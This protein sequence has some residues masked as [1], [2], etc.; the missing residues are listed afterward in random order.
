MRSSSCCCRGP[1]PATTYAELQVVAERIRRRVA[2]LRVE[3]PTPDGPLTITDLSASLGGAVFPHDG[4]HL[5]DILAVADTALYAAKRA[6][7]NAVRMG[8]PPGRGRGRARP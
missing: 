1:P 6:G 5:L 7:R 4:S 2:E 3:I 8:A